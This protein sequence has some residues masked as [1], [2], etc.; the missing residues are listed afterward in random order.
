MASAGRSRYWGLLTGPQV[1]V[2]SF[3]LTIAVGT[4][5]LSLPLASA[6][7]QSIGLLDAYFTAS[8]ATCVTGLVVLDTGADFSLFGQLV[9]LLLIQVGGLGLMAMTTLVFLVM[10]RRITLRSRLLIQESFGQ[11]QL[12]GLVRLIKSIFLFT[13]ASEAVGAV[14]LTLR[15]LPEMPTGEAVYKGIFH[16]VSAF[17]N[18][19]FDLFGDSLVR[20][21]AD[22]VVVMVVSILVIAGGLG[23][24]VLRNLINRR[25]NGRLTLH[26]KVVIRTSIV[27][28]ALGFGLVL[29]LEW[30]NPATIGALPEH[31]KVLAAWFTS[32]TPRTAGFNTLP[33]AMLTNTTLLVLMVF[34]LIGASPGGTGGGIKTTTFWMML[35]SVFTTIRGRRE[36]TSNGRSVPRE[37]ADR[38]VAIVVMS[39]GLIALVTGV[40]LVTERAGPLAVLF[41]T[42]SAFGTVGLSLGL[43]PELSVVGRILVPLTMLAGRVGPFTLVVALNSQRSTADVHLPEER[44]LVG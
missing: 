14:I 33:T 19:G 11:S 18:A 16:S 10:G 27:L 40:L 12:A 43:T 26:S 31:G 24:P 39:L 1:I 37:L 4:V 22:P 29:A 5:L 8:S 34:M 6:T 41:E 42:V 23:F 3:V 15:F 38:A 36:I 2:L 7:G 21:A 35:Q 20:Y 13:L 17:C 30:G 28:L 32:V 44:I 9:I 25:Q